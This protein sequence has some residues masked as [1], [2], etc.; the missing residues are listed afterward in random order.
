MWRFDSSKILLT[1]GMLIQVFPLIG[2][3][4]E[5]KIKHDQIKYELYKEKLESDGT[6]ANWQQQARF[7]AIEYLENLD[8]ANYQ[9][10]WQKCDALL[11]RSIHEDDWLLD[12]KTSRHYLGN[13]TSRN[14]TSQ[15]MTWD[16]AGLPQGPYFVIEYE[17]ASKQH[18]KL[19]ETITLRRGV[20]NQWN[21]LI[22]QIN[23]EK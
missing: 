7:A 22:Y 16:P 2:D 18:P 23:E 8:K 5:E 15:K 1:F 21:V 12:L 9:A 17:A 3:S 6:N 19:A 14:Q 11:K 13:I 20:D 10:C 4:T